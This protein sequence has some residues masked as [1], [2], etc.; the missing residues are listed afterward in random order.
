MIHINIWGLRRL[1]NMGLNTYLVMGRRGEVEQLLRRA[2]EFLETA[3]YQRS[4]GFY[5]LAAFSLKQALQLHLKAKI[6]SMGV[7]YP[8]TH[9]V[10]TLLRI[11][12]EIAP[13]A[14]RA[15]VEQIL[16]DYLLELGILEDAYITSRYV[17]RDYTEEEIDKLMNTV[18]R[19]MELVP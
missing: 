9:S 7:E 16:D 15:K 8:R 2:R 6:L 1:I 13:E 4:R 19:V 11:L 17:T 10:R 18:K 12:S 3:E 5:D 14:E